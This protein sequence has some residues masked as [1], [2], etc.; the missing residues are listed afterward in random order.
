MVL[1]NGTFVELLPSHPDHV[2][3][4]LHLWNPTP[5]GIF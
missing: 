4:L 2:C 5:L 3:N 1:G